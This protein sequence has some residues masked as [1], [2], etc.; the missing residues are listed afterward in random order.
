MHAKQFNELGNGSNGWLRRRRSLALICAAFILVLGAVAFAGRP[1][2]AGAPSSDGHAEALPVESLRLEALS[3]V[4]TNALYAGTVE[5]NRSAQ[6]AFE[7]PGR[8]ATVLVREGSVVSKGQVLAQLDTAEL[9]VQRLQAESQLAQAEAV[10][11]ELVSGPREELIAGARAQVRE[12]EEQLHLLE[13]QLQRRQDLLRREAISREEMDS[14]S[15]Q[16]SAQT[17]RLDATRERL[18]ELQAGTRSEQVDAQR[19]VVSLARARVQEL[20]LLIERSSLR[21]PFSG[22]IARRALDEGAY[23]NPGTPVLELLEA[24]HL[25]I[26]VGLPPDQLTAAM[27]GSTQTVVLNGHRFVT[28]VERMLPQ[29]ETTTRVV[30]ILLAVPDDARPMVLPGMLAHLEL[31]RTLQEPGYRVPVS[32]LTRADRGLWACFVILQEQEQRGFR[33]L[34]RREVE[35]LHTDGEFVYVRGLVQ[36]GEDIVASG[37]SRVTDGQRVLVV[38][39]A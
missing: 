5:A 39:E 7:R 34:E 11:R 38:K 4:S 6:L 23:V 12:A 37:L 2:D 28:R 33:L 27:P 21:A 32:A 31:P 35:I 14:F 8:L 19:S 13:L 24:G 10:Q 1:G 30:P 18:R 17:A 3:T 15:T 26:R 25:E 16:V 36:P 20:N 29:L 22:R 9:E